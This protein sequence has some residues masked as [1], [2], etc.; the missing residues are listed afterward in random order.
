MFP[1]PKGFDRV[2]VIQCFLALFFVLWFL[3]RPDWGIY[4][5]WPVK[6]VLT[7]LFLGRLHAAH[8]FW[9]PPVA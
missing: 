4:F 7:T 1:K 6:P 5:A 3:I 2:G 9:I 8:V